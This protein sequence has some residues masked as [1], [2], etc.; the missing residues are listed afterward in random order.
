MS[1]GAI[2]MTIVIAVIVGVTAYLVGTL[3]RSIQKEKS[4]KMKLWK[5]FGLSLGFCLLFFVT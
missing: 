3:A 2:A 5:N 1:G 4:T